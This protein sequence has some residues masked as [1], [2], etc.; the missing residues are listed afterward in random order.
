[1]TIL[2]KRLYKLKTHFISLF[3]VSH[4]TLSRDKLNHS[5]RLC[6]ERHKEEFHWK[7]VPRTRNTFMVFCD[8]FSF[9]LYFCYPSLVSYP[10]IFL[11]MLL[12]PVTQGSTTFISF[13]TIKC[14][15]KNYI[16]YS[17]NLMAFSIST[18]WESSLT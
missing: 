11:P 3:I 9:K 8:L 18:C 14:T 6:R 10:Y 5:L 12:D 13:N 1:M 7:L 17:M 15:N 4:Q 16:Q 2:H